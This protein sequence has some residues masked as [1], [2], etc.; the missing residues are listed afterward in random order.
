MMDLLRKQAERF[1]ARYVSGTVE[2]VDF[3]KAPFTL[4]V[5][6]NERTSDAVI[7]CTGATA[8]YL[9]LTSEQELLGRGV[10]ACATCD[11][12]FYRGREVAVVGGG[13]TAAEEALF[14]TRYASKVTLIH[15]R[16]ELRASKIMRKRVAESVKIEMRW[17]SVVE[18]VLGDPQQGGVTGLKLKDVETDA[19]TELA[20]HGVFVAIGHKPNTEPFTN[21]LETDEVGYIKVAPGTT[22]TGVDGVFAAGDVID[23]V[24][25][26]AITAAGTGCMAAIDC[27]RWLAEKEG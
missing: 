21:A 18:E 19:V 10:S 6:G 12:F 2:S 9:G 27:E 20:C 1:G 5:D 16:D 3:S 26:Q 11:G 13:D 4:R 22:R 7:I 23:R 15:R 17:N 25:R 14:L 24:Y 8:K